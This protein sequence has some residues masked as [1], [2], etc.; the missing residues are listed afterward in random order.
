[1]V[2]IVRNFCLSG[3]NVSW[4]NAI[5]KIGYIKI[6]YDESKS[7]FSDMYILADQIAQ[8]IRETESLQPVMFAFHYYEPVNRKPTLSVIPRFPNDY[9][10]H[11]Y[12]YTLSE[13]E[14]QKETTTK[15]AIEPHI[16]NLL[17]RFQC[18]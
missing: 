14:E 12:V 5:T 15:E 8:S 1:M 18:K 2:S 6:E 13:L 3:F 9:E 16:N 10:N 17:N 11:N 4:I 7:N